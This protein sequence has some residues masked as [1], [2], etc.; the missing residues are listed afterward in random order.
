MARCFICGQPGTI[1]F[2]RYDYN[3]EATLFWS[4][5]RLLLWLFIFNITA[6]P[7]S[8]EE[9]ARYMICAQH[10]IN[11]ET[12]VHQAQRGDINYFPN[13]I[14]MTAIQKQRRARAVQLAANQ[15]EPQWPTAMVIPDIDTDASAR[16]LPVEQI[17][18][19][20]Q[21]FFSTNR[22]PVGNQFYTYVALD[23]RY[24]DKLVNDHVS[25]HICGTHFHF[26]CRCIL[27]SK[28]YF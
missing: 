10:Q 26:Q 23:S 20:V 28:S 14:G 12:P 19:A 27:S 24:I 3:T 6:T 25:F 13:E 15:E 17:T 2:P 22:K 16:R 21:K 1:N 11:E 9:V 8:N 18:A 5:F 4:T 7:M